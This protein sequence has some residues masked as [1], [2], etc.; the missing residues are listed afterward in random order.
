MKS[1]RVALVVAG[2]LAAAAIIALWAFESL[3]YVTEEVHTPPSFAARRNP[4]LAL[5]R[6]LTPVPGVV[7]YSSASDI[8]LNDAGV[9]VL[10]A[11]DMSG[12]GAKELG[13]WVYG[14]GRLVLAFTAIEEDEDAWYEEEDENDEDRAYE[15]DEGYD[16]YEDWAYEEDEESIE[17]EDGILRGEDAG[18]LLESFGYEEMDAPVFEPPFHGLEPSYRMDDEEWDDIT[19]R[20]VRSEPLDE[21]PPFITVDTGVN[22]DDAAADLGTGVYY[23]NDMPKAV[24]RTYGRGAIFAGGEPYAFMNE[25]LKLQGN[26]KLADFMFGKSALK[27]WVPVVRYAETESK[28]VRRLDAAPVLLSLALVFAMLL[29][30]SGP[31]IGAFIPD[32]IRQRRSLRERFQAEGH[33]LWRRGAGNRIAGKDGD[34]RMSKRAFVAEVNARIDDKKTGAKT[35]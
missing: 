20:F 11:D 13:E 25:G 23:A 35:T 12:I 32:E 33:F 4:W 9:V 22:F 7:R 28:G 15:G 2:S 31:R 21:L 14:G 10:Y 18:E 16:G 27:A 5:S 26:R 34:R 30:M 24:I 29:W 19:D 6:S 1:A 17:D 3:E 8:D